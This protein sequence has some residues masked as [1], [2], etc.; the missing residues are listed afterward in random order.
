MPDLA[1]LADSGGQVKRA[2]VEKA[3]SLV[4]NADGHGQQQTFRGGHPLRH[5]IIATL[6]IMLL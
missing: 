4:G 2:G 6:L 5:M 3:P 1:I